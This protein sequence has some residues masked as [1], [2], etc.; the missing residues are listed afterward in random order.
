MKW[1]AG[2]PI[3]GIALV[4]ACAPT[5]SVYGIMDGEVYTGTTT[6]ESQYGDMTITNGKGKTCVGERRGAATMLVSGGGHGLLTCND[7]TQ[8]VIQYTKT[9]FASGH[10]FGTSSDGNTVRFTFGLSP[11]E[12]AKYL[13]QQPAQAAAG[14]PGAPTPPT[15]AKSTGSGFF[16]TRQG[17]LITNA[18]VVEGCKEVTVAH[19]GSSPSSATIVAKDKQNDLALLQA[20]TPV[21]AIAALRGARQIRQGETVVAYGFPLTGI[22]SSGG[23]LTTGTVSALT[24]SRDDTRYLQVS[25]QIQPGNSGGPLMDMTGAI[26]GVTTASLDD[27]KLVRTTG[28]VPQNVNFALKADVVRTFLAS[29]G[30]AA[31]T[32]SGGR[33]LSLPDVGERARA[34]TALIEC[35]R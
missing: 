2:L 28:A 3:V 25:T 13:G 19:I 4:T 8:I 10:G 15:R 11:D 22:V 9:G 33:E 20:G 7:G 14:A 18:H 24:G 1:R 16:I 17:H 12:S 34:F 5:L 23:T 31:E 35:K 21:P 32:A 30:V 26:V 6:G 27:A 29:A